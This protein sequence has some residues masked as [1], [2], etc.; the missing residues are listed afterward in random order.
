V[1]FETLKELNAHEKTHRGINFWGWNW[2]EVAAPASAPNP[3]ML[4]VHMSV[5]ILTLKL[6]KNPKMSYKQVKNKEQSLLS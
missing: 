1:K 5:N 2:C 3:I 6:K 4:W